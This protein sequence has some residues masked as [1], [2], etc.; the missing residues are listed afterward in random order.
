[1]FG[2]SGR[3]IAPAV[4]IMGQK[5]ICFIGRNNVG[6]PGVDQGKGASSRADI[7]RLPQTVKNQDLAI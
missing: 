2:R 7:H 1:M 5:I 3:E 6:M 4:E